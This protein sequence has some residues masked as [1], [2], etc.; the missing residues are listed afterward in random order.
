MLFSDP[1][2]DAVGGLAA[3]SVRSRALSAP[4]FEDSK[5]VQCIP[6]RGEL[7]TPHLTCGNVFKTSWRWGESNPRPSASQQAFSERSR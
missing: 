5:V 3:E 7:G 1:I 4:Y 6:R 2:T